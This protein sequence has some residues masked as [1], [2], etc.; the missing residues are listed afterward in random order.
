MYR[1]I[2]QLPLIIFLH[3]SGIFS[4]FEQDYEKA[5]TFLKDH[6][7]LI[8]SS[9]T[10][11][12]SDTSVVVSVLFPE[13]V[14]YSA[15]FDFFETKS[16]ELIYVLYGS[17]Y[18]D[19]SIGSLQMKPSFVEKLET[20]MSDEPLLHNFSALTEYMDNDPQAVRRERIERLKSFDWQL[21]YINCFYH[22]VSLRFDDMQ[23]ADNSDKIKFFASAYNHGFDNDQEKIR[24]WSMKKTFPYGS[25]FPDNPYSYCDV[26]L[27]FYNNHFQEFIK[28][29]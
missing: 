20:Y 17:D 19:F 26:S 25:K 5:L 6:K 1:L 8:L 16:L 22:I 21:T 28:T 9:C 3:I 7:E 2:L 18:A 15:F 27:D 11:Y 10:K 14:R 24:E 13:L 29:K 4:D 12:D 23:N